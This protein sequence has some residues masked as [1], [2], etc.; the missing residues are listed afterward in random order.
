MDYLLFIKND[1]Y[2]GYVIKWRNIND[3]H[4]SGIN[5]K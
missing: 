4:L 2:V 5:R 3:I 1:N